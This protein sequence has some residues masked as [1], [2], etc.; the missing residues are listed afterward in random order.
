MMAKKK[1]GVSIALVIGFCLFTGVLQF[2]PIS[3]SFGKSN[4]SK[5][6]LRNMPLQPNGTYLV[7]VKKPMALPDDME[8]IEQ[9]TSQMQ[10][11]GARRGAGFVHDGKRKDSDKKKCMGTI[12]TLLQDDGRI[13]YKCLHCG[14][15]IPDINTKVK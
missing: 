1:L 8:L 13:K 2:V 11:L 15:V 4:H 7:Y 3:I 10:R 14:K 12:K 5:S 9:W 6:D